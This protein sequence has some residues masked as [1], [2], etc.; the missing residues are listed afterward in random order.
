M[1]LNYV[2]R[3]HFFRRTTS[4]T[5]HVCIYTT[6]RLPTTMVAS[7]WF[8]IVSKWRF[9]WSLSRANVHLDVWIYC[10]TCRY[11]F[12]KKKNCSIFHLHFVQFYFSKCVELWIIINR[13]YP[14]MDKS[15]NRPTFT[16][17]QTVVIDSKM[18]NWIILENSNLVN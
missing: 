12:E 13:V 9:S 3:I 2:S 8:S 14:R 11:I 1:L 10:D 4:K 17:H 5:L 7:V 6:I 18:F 15:V 16:L